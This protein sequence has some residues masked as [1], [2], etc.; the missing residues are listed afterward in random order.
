MI[1]CDSI[2]SSYV[3]KCFAYASSGKTAGSCAELDGG[4]EACVFGDDEAVYLPNEIG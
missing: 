3:I 4:D 2:D 1:S